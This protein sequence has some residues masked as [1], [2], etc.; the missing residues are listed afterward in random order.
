[1]FFIHFN[2]S[3]TNSKVA[4]LCKQFSYNSVKTHEYKP[5]HKRQMFCKLSELKSSVDQSQMLNAEN[6]IFSKI[7]KK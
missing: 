6:I 1:M 5:Q 4:I 3:M 2:V 7:L